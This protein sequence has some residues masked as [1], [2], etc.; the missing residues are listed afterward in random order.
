MLSVSTQR[1]IDYG[2]DGGGAMIITILLPEHG[3]E[4][5]NEI[6]RANGIE[7]AWRGYFHDIAT[8]SG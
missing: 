1:T 5:A 8:P 3:I 7:R 4:R 2:S 6:V